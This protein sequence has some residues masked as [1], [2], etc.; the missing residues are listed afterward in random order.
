MR[1]GVFGGTFDP[2][3]VGH[4][5]VALDAF[6]RLALDHMVLIPAAQQPLKTARPPVA[7]AEH[8]LAMVRL[9]VG[10]AAGFEVSALE[11]ERAGLSYTVETLELL[12]RRFEGARL[13]LLVGADVPDTFEHWREPERIRALADLVVLRRSP[14]EATRP[15]PGFTHL[16]TRRVD[17]SS[18]E[19]RE[20]A[21]RG[22]TLQGF[23]TD[24]VA[25]Y[26][27]A[28]GLYR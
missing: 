22:L 10:D 14:S 7:A 6:E 12:A 18:T 4:W 23:V 9:L 13:F 8:R 15:Y 27:S 11:I 26:V 24:S 5:L 28:H 17:V 20:R 19:I 1:V 21:R 2:P 16:D 25:A 3:H